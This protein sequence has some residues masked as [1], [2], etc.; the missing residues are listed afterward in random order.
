MSLASALYVALTTA[1]GPS[2]RAFVPRCPEPLDGPYGA[3]QMTYDLRKVRLKGFVT[4]I[5]HTNS[6]TLMSEWIRLAI[7]GTR[8]VSLIGSLLRNG[9]FQLGP[10]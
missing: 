5:P 2:A 4:R 10:C 9:N 3:A 7:T 8:L 6:S 1:V